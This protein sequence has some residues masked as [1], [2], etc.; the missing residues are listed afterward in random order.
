MIPKKPAP[1]LPRGE[2][3]FSEKI[4]LESKSAGHYRERTID[5]AQDA[6]E[7]MPTAHDETSCGD[8]AVNAL[9][10]CKLWILLDAVDRNFGAAAKD[11]EN[12]AILQK[13]DRVIAPL[14]S[15]DLAAI[16]TQQAI[17]LAPIE[18]HL[19]GGD[20]A[21]GYLAPKGLAWFSIAWTNGHRRLPV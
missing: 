20:E 1:G 10:A 17:K 5:R 13:I 14:T 8:H 18:G 15:G 6:I 19:L 3:W 11:G 7:L 2:S 9:A 16:E 4:M 21:R 12:R